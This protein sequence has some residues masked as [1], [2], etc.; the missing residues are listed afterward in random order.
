[1][2][3]KGG[4]M[5]RGAPVPIVAC[6]LLLL[7]SCA[8]RPSDP[9]GSAGAGGE[10]SRSYLVLFRVSCD[11]CSIRWSVG[12]EVGAVSDTALWHHRE[13]VAVLPG[14]PTVA[15]LTAAPMPG[16]KAVSWVRISVDGEVVAEASSDGSGGA[17]QR[18]PPRPLSVEVPVPSPPS[19]EQPDVR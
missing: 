17:D 14:Q 2:L 19:G 9:F 5:M 15:R 4:R 6:S 8:S 1:M 7:M 3:P 13:R 18:L 10:G 16:A 11:A 12:P